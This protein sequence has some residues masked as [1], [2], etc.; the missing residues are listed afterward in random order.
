M[1]ISALVGEAEADAD[2]E[3]MLA[4]WLSTLSV[5]C[6]VQSLSSIRV[7]SRL[8]S[9]DLVRPL[10]SPWYTLYEG[11]QDDALL[12][13]TGLNLTGFQ[14]LLAGFARHYEVRS[15]P[16]KRGR[17]PRFLDK[18]AV[19]GCIL[20]FYRQPVERT[21]LC[22][23]FGIPPSTLSRVLSNAERALLAAL[24]EMPAAAIVWPTKA[25]Q[26]EMAARVEARHPLIRNCF[27]FID[28]K[29]YRVQ[30]P[31]QSDIQNAY[32]NGRLR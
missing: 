31:T 8:R 27:G 3:E 19:L 28:G 12:E 30:E 29:N 22:E 7:R 17:P 24:T 5:A 13:T 23:L 4:L 25:K 9:S 15:G 1:M 18:H 11:R 32:Y 20:H 2:E 16:G 14:R 10:R 21:I 26:A 6:A